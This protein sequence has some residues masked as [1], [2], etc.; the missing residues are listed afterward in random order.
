MKRYRPAFFAAGV[1]FGFILSRTGISDFR[2]IHG[3]FT[4][5]DFTVGGVMLA[6]IITAYAGMRILRSRKK[7]LDGQPLQI[8][9]KKLHKYS[10]AGALLFGI[11]WGI[12]GAC[13]GTVLV[14]LGEGKVLALFTFSGMVAGTLLYA[15]M[16]GKNSA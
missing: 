4:G 1:Y 3:F 8:K 14:Q 11:G 2:L 10:L 15:S 13:P 9:H 5:K 6:A 16:K 12:S 7:T